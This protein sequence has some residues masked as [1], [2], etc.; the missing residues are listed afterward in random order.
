MTGSSHEVLMEKLKNAL[1]AP[2]LA[3]LDARLKQLVI[4]LSPWHGDALVRD[5]LAAIRQ[6]I[7]AARMLE[8][9]YADSEG[10]RTERRV[11]PYSLILKG[12]IWYLYAWC[13]LRQDFRYFRIS[14]IRSFRETGERFT[15]RELLHEP[16]PTE[17]EWET[18]RKLIP[19][20]LKFSPQMESIITE[21]FG[22]ETEKC[23]DGRIVLRTAYPEEN[24]LYGFLL[25]FG[26]EL[27]VVSP[28]HIRSILAVISRKI[29]EKYAPE[30]DIQASCS[31]CYDSHKNTGGIS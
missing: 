30:H 6:A 24:W 31:M 4:D 26:D 1:P 9:T 10:Q 16:I 8:L 18:P 25:S 19:L 21:W 20:E 23:D 7:E 15:M 27:E 22:G 12:S 5:K 2:Q 14:R 17:P 3:M 11:E 28:P 13:A 29:F